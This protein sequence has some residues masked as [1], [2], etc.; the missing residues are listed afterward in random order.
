VFGAPNLMKSGRSKLF[1]PTAQVKP[2]RDE[3][4]RMLLASYRVLFV[5]WVFSHPERALA[6]ILT[7]QLVICEL[8]APGLRII[9]TINQSC[10]VAVAGDFKPAEVT[11]IHVYLFPFD[12]LRLDAPGGWTGEAA[13]LKQV[14][15]S[16]PLLFDVG[17]G[18]TTVRMKL[19]AGQS[20]AW[21]PFF[22]AAWQPIEFSTLS[23]DHANSLPVALDA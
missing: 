8:A 16:V 13:A 19:D 5:L 3:R 12:K 14:V 10:V 21:L 4:A 1:K 23:A 15:S 6:I 9:E 2:K 11:P 20:F 7:E 17:T 22:H 18:S